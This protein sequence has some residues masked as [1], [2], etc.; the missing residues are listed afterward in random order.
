VRNRIHGTV[1]FVSRQVNRAVQ[2]ILVSLSWS[3]SGGPKLGSPEKI[4]KNVK[5]N[6]KKK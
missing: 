1:Y 4:Y 2:P 5:T 3:L 6:V